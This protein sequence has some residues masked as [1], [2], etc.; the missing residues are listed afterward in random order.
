[1]NINCYTVNLVFNRVAAELGMDPI[2]VALRNDGAE[3]HDMVW[4]DAKKVE[5]GFPVRDSLKECVD[6]GKAA[7]AWEQKWHAPGTK[8]LRNGKL[9]G[10]GFTWTHEWD[11]SAG[12][13]EIGMY[14]ERNDG[15]VTILA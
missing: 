2:E 15:S 9:H 10:L 1:M 7:I 4:L 5:L 13:S 3:G 8:T 6:K 11:D 12:S 14:F